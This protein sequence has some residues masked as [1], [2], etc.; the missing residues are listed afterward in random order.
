MSSKASLKVQ[1]QQ[2]GIEQQNNYPWEG[3]LKFI[4]TP[5]TSSTF[6]IRIRIPGWARNQAMPSDLYSFATPLKEKVGV[7]VNGQVVEYNMEKGY[8][9]IHK[10]WK[11]GDVVEVRLPMEVQRVVANENVRDDEGKVAL[12]RGPLIYCAEGVDNDGRASNILVPVE[13]AFHAENKPELLNGVEVLKAKVPVI[14][15]D[16]NGQN[17]STVI[18]TITAIPYYAWA[19]RGEGEMII[20]FPTKVTEIDLFPAEAK[21]K[22]IGK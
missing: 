9:V 3:D 2:V 13:A 5:Q 21:A 6:N 22:T 4:V 8:A 18:K 19:N 10:K 14:N 15:I 20:W 11:K 16:S 7:K 12:Q 17:V 1:G